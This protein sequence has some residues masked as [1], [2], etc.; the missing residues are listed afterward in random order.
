MNRRWVLLFGVTVA[1]ASCRSSPESLSV[2]LSA[3]STALATAVTV[4]QEIG[5]PIQHA[6][7]LVIIAEGFLNAQNREDAL[8]VAAETVRLVNE[9]PMSTEVIRLQLRTAELLL[10]ADETDGAR[11]LITEATTFTNALRDESARADLLPLIIQA[12][13]AGDDDTRDLLPAAVDPVY[14]IEDPGLRAETFIAIAETYQSVGVGQS[15]TGLIQQ[16]IPAIR[17]VADPFRR[18]DLFAGLSCRA[19]AAGEDDLA[20]ALVEDA[21]EQLTAGMVKAE[22]DPETV[23]VVFKAV[24]RDLGGTEAMISV[25]GIRDRYARAVG[26]LAVAMAEGSGPSAELALDRAVDAAYYITD[27]EAYSALM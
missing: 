22:P 27:P 5:D 10:A 26:F 2:T 25:C 9:I 17:S 14:I 3:T 1:V 21:Q 16:A 19:F 18:A 4:A 24:T 13:I 11:R 20:R 6:E 12:A 15:V 8:Q 7:L 23:A